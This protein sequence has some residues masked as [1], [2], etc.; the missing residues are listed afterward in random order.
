MIR[1]PWRRLEPRCWPVLQGVLPLRRARVSGDVLAGVTLA[2]LGI[3]EC[4]GPP[5]I[6]WSARTPQRPPSS[7]RPS[8]GSPSPD[9]PQYVQL[10]GLAA[11]LAGGMLLLGR[12]ARLGFLANF[13]SRTVLVGFLT[14]VGIQVAAGQLPDMLGVKSSGSDTLSKRGV[15]AQGGPADGDDTGGGCWEWT[16]YPASPLDTVTAT[17]GS[18]QDRSLTWLRQHRAHGRPS[19]PQVAQ[20]GSGA[21]GGVTREDGSMAPT[22]AASASYDV[23]LGVGRALFPEIRIGRPGRARSYWV[24]IA[25]MRALRARWKVDIEGVEKVS[26]GA[27]I[28]I[29]THVS[30]ADPLVVVMSTWWRVTAFTKLEWFQGRSALF[31]RL[32]GQIPLRRGDQAATDWAIDMA[33]S[34]LEHGGKIG[35]YPEGTRSPDPTKLH[36]LHPRVLIPVLRTNPDVPAYAVAT[37]YTH[38]PLR[39][40]RVQVRISSRLPLDPSTMTSESIITVVREALLGL[41][42]Q[43]YVDVSARE[44]KEN[45][46]RS[47]PE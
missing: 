40:T 16:P 8:S 26:R 35:L 45:R 28:L 38:R 14:E 33:S 41:G 30:A 10:A 22:G 11:L 43:T 34:A 31:F 36:R 21:S 13:L 39:R 2:A 19:A 18:G 37:A 46:A 17:P 15:E 9:R 24:T 23:L 5:A 42:G 32:M 44:A 29:G 12:L 25:A 1:V 3:P 6:S 20:V 47:L 4:S 27:A 7:A